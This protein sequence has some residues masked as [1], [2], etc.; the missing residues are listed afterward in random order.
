M[1]KF[2]EL[3]DAY[4]LSRKKYFD[5]W[6][7]CAIFATN[8]VNGVVDYFECPREQ[9]SFIPLKE[10]PKPNT[11]YTLRGAMHLDED[12]FWHLGVGLTLYTAP[13]IFPHERTILPFLI[14]KVDDNFIVKLGP[15]GKEFRDST[16]KSD[17]FKEFFDFIFIKIK[18]RYEKGLQ[19][20]LEQ[21]ET[22]RKIGF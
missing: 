12:T 18:E 7:A 1:S 16:D 6:D 21:N 22:T 20:F 19:K 2:K 17:R 5:Y 15:E 11:T 9:I 8:L 13:N 4:T 3:C 14:K 10:T